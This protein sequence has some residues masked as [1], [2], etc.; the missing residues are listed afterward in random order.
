MDRVTQAVTLAQQIR[1]NGAVTC[2]CHICVDDPNEKDG[3][4]AFCIQTAA[5]RGHPTCLWLALVL[6]R[7]SYTQR[8]KVRR[9]AWATS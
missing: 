5:K 3:H 8:R 9:L 2:C 1:G 7:C 4:V 6:A